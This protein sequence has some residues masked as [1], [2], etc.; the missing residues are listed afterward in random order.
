MILR[1]LKYDTC[2]NC[3]NKLSNLFL[4]LGYAPPSNSYLKKDDLNFS[5]KTLPL[6][7][8]FVI[9]VGWYKHD[10]ADPTELFDLIMLIILRFQKH[11]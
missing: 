5:E 6:E 9:N 4:D 3:K 11:G 10:F 2:R 8:L 1:A 7:Y